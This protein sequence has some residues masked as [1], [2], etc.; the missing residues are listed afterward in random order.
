[1]ITCCVIKLLY[2]WR[3]NRKMGERA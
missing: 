2:N 3:S 1:M